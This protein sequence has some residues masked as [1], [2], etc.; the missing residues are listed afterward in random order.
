M[1]GIMDA[2]DAIEFMFAGASA[3]AVGTA[4]FVN[5][6]TVESIIDGMKDYLQR[7]GIDDVKEIIGAMNAT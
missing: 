6:N 4:N 2:K 5:P 1:G 3:V 7:N